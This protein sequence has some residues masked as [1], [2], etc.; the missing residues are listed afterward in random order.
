L[1]AKRI[2]FT[3][4]IPASASPEFS[5]SGVT[6]QWVLRLEFITSAM[7]SRSTADSQEWLVEDL[8]EPTFADDRGELYEPKQNVFAESFEASIAVKI[9]PNGADPGGMGAV[10]SSQANAAAIVG[11]AV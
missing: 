4:T 8:L 6:V 9:Y 3:P 7:S 11:F 10:V 5:T 1:F 2:I